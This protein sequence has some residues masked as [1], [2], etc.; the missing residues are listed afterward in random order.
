M[1]NIGIISPNSFL[2]KSCIGIIKYIFVELSW[3][4]M[5]FYSFCVYICSFVVIS[6]GNASEE[7][8]ESLQDFQNTSTLY[9]NSDFE[10]PTLSENAKFYMIQWGAFDDFETETKA[11]NGS[12]IEELRP[13]SER[14]LARIDSLTKKIPDT[15]FTQP[16]YSR[17][18]VAKTRAELLQ[19]ETH[20]SRVDSVKLQTYIDEMNIAAKN[21][22]VQINEK[23]EK[24]AIDLQKKD[25]EKK[26]LEKQKRFLDSVYRAELRDKNGN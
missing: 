14:L 9:G 21:L 22:I 7:P 16:I 3:L 26:E 19:Q 18:I 11:I 8:N 6:C 10:F 5:K 1:V 13:K 20:K 23:F 12:T 2:K 4:P 25:Y 15:L 24:D 17:V